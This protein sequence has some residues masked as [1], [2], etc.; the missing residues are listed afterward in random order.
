M[1]WDIPSSKDLG[2]CEGALSCY[3]F[4]FH[5]DRQD[6]KIQYLNFSSQ[7]I[8]HVAEA[9]ECHS[10]NIKVLSSQRF[11]APLVMTALSELKYSGQVT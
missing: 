2:N 1:Q 6:R 8:Q 4:I 11:H 7:C 5:Q 9:E 3:L 10:D